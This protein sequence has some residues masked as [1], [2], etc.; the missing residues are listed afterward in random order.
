M[1]PEVGAVDAKLVRS[2]GQ[3]K[4][5]AQHFTRVGPELTRD[6]VMTKTEESESFHGTM[7]HG[8]S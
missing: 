1:H 7:L 5:N 4:F 8:I 6:R 3:F 2:L